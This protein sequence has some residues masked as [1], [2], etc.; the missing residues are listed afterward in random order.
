MA[1]KVFSVSG[2]VFE[3]LLVLGLVQILGLFVLLSTVLN[4]L[5][6]YALLT[7][8]GILAS[9]HMRIHRRRGS[10]PKRPI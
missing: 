1:R 4:F 2:A 3:V 5:C 8:K 10:L 7:W 6:K 9:A